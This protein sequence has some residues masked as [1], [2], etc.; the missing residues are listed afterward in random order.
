MTTAG[1]RKY[2][3]QTAHDDAAESGDN[4]GLNEDQ[5]GLQ[6]GEAD[7]LLEKNGHDK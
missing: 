3:G 5:T 2:V 7:D 4:Q 1:G 6:G